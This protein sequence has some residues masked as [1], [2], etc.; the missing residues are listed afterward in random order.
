MTYREHILEVIICGSHIR[1]TLQL[2]LYQYLQLLH[3]SVNPTELDKHHVTCHVA[4][5]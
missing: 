3:E 2:H 5:Q 4:R 1:D